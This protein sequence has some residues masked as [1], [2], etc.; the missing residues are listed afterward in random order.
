[1]ADHFS[2][3]TTLN[4]QIGVMTKPN[5]TKTP[6]TTTAEVEASLEASTDEVEV[7]A[8]AA[9]T[10]RFEGLKNSALPLATTLLVLFAGLTFAALNSNIGRLDTRIDRLEDRMEQRFE[11][12]DRRFEA[13]DAKF[14]A[15]FEAQDAKFEARFEAQDAK[16]EARFES[17]DETLGEINLKLTAL[18]AALNATEGVDAALEGTLLPNPQ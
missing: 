2:I 15:R 6:T 10:K 18:I 12:I 8:T 9:R 17:I 4:D 14:E 13:Q 16:F 3:S 7:V 11:A 5:K 1:M